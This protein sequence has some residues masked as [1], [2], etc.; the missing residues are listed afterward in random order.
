MVDKIVFSE[1]ASSA[2]RV[3]DS[4]WTRGDRQ[5]DKSNFG[6]VG[7]DLQL[8]TAAQPFGAR[9]TMAIKSVAQLLCARARAD[10]HGLHCIRELR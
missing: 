7:V 5:S 4:S 10:D 2:K 9:A 1:S 6:N 3:N 8:Q